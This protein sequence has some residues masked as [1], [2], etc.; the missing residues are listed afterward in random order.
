MRFR[1]LA[2]TAAAAGFFAAAQANAAVVYSTDTVDYIQLG[3]TIGSE[4]DKI[5]LGGVT[6]SFTGAGTYVVN[7]V[8]FTVGIN[9]SYGPPYDMSGT[10]SDTGLADG[11]P[12][13]Y[14]VPYT[15]T[16]S[17]SDTIVIGGNSFTAGG[18]N[19]TFDTLTLSNGDTSTPVTGDLTVRVTAVPEPAAWVLMI[20]GF[21]LVGVAA[22]RRRTTRIA[23]A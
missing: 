21:T 17:T 2:L 23:F 19:F 9:A 16:I 15:I 12:F 22:R 18:Y 13:S 11:N 20:G 5:T 7:L 1:T 4:F 6:G 3:D 10:F 14:S 8:T